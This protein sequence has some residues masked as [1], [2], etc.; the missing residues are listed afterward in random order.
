MGELLTSFGYGVTT[1]TSGL[2][3]ASLVKRAQFDLAIIDFMM[4]GMCGR[5]LAPAIK[6]HNPQIPII[7]LS[8]YPPEE[9]PGVD[10]LFKKPIEPATL[11]ALVAVALG[12]DD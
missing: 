7:M 1:L 3:A 5:E 8:A 11:E 10:H 6:S 2:E 4:P 12:L 9:M